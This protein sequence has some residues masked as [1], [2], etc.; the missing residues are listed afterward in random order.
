MKEL[1]SYN[2]TQTGLHAKEGRTGSEATL[3]I[4]DEK[5]SKIELERK[6]EEMR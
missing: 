4:L 3:K 1:H 5:V 2:S 6:L